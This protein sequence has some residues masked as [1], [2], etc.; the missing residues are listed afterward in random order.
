MRKK[1]WIYGVSTLLIIAVAA[2]VILFGSGIFPFEGNIKEEGF[3]RLKR[4]KVERLA[5]LK[6]YYSDQEKS[7]M[8]LENDKLLIAEF[9]KMKEG[10]VQLSRQDEERIDDHFV[11]NYAT[12]YN[13]LF[14]DST[15]FV[16]H[17]IRQESDYLQNI[18]TGEL[19]ETSLARHLRDRRT[20]D[21]SGYEYYPPS[22]EAAAFFSV[23]VYDGMQFE[24]W[25]VLQNDINHINVVLNNPRDLGS[26][27]E[28]YLVNEN[29][30]M[31]SNSR[32]IGEGTTLRKHVDTKAVRNA[33]EQ[34]SGE[35]IINDYRGVMVY[36]SYE[37]LTMHGQ[38]WV[39]L[40]EMDESEILRDYYLSHS[41]D[42]L[43]K[44]LSLLAQN[45][46]PFHPDPD[47]SFASEKARRVDMNE[48]GNVSGRE[49]LRTWGVASCTAMVISKDS[50]FAYMAHLTPTDVVYRRFWNFRGSF[51]ESNFTE[52]L[53][54]HIRRYR[55]YRYEW[56]LLNVTL[57]APHRHSI[58]SL[59]DL[60]LDYQI[61]P[62]R[63]RFMYNPEARGANVCYDGA[64]NV[65]VAEWYTDSGYSYQKSA[66]T[67]SLASLIKTVL[68]YD[69]LQV[70]RE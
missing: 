61:D 46:E 45:T 11:L 23:P 50:V 32:F 22:G 18:F 54:R 41:G 16:F 35:C 7:A 64:G 40:V 4:I 17:S 51:E 38:S 1:N 12:F 19:K 37:K 60:L 49:N 29:R 57:I 44:M 67:R 21:F 24:G 30:L 3:R 66:D 6:K 20:P 58:G 70:R 9:L 42:L 69:K 55:V 39:L 56:P 63:I 43:P 59:V 62:S 13:L 48:Y 8:N 26:T 14:I 10:D 15:G 65:T 33:L 36:S 5:F 28:V 2:A 47:T 27:G 52:T 25:F 34:S 68:N 53:I 31:L